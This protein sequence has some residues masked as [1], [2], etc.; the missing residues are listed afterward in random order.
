MHI[1]GCAK[2]ASV[3]LLSSWVLG[4]QA[5]LRTL[6]VALRFHLVAPLKQDDYVKNTEIASFPDPLRKHDNYQAA[7][8][9]PPPNA[10]PT[11]P[12]LRKIVRNAKFRQSLIDWV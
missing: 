12:G 5:R 9:A 2:V 3:K 1:G 8:N 7:P 6:R 10:R 4:F 11:S